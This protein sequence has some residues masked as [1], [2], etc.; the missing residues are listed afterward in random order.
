MFGLEMLDVAIGVIFV[1]LLLSLICSAANEV[2]EA[3]LKARAKYLFDGIKN[4]LSQEAD[5]NETVKTDGENN[6]VKKLYEHPLVFSLF[7][8]NFNG[9]VRNLPSY[10][11][12]QNFAKALISVIK[13][14]SPADIQQAIQAVPNERLKKSLEA[15][16]SDA[17]NDLNKAQASIETWYN[18]S[19]DR[20]AGWY[21]R[22]V[23]AI[24]FF[25]GLGVVIFLNADSISIINALTHDQPLRNSLVVAS[26]E[27]A[28]VAAGNN[29][30]NAHTEFKNR[31]DEIKKLGLPIGWNRVANECS[32]AALDKCDPK[33]NSSQIYILMWAVFGWLMTATAI[34]LGAP[35]WF[36]LLN[37]FMVVRSTVKPK[38]K[39]PEEKPKD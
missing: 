35:F 27:Y 7:Q 8:G 12:A 38:E 13:E 36:D 11:P 37:K 17:G 26:G 22:R 2:I 39:S 34:S 28:K 4:L 6:F 3:A 31:V 18:N 24:L 29:N 1:Y 14:T 19:M 20:V 33:E 15:L 9:R 30:S 10:I 32:I 5:T 16:L 25:L 23:Q 21:K